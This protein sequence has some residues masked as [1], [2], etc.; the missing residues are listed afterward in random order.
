MGALERLIVIAHGLAV[1][2]GNSCE[3]LIHDVR[4][5]IDKSLVY[6]EN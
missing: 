3:V 6:I 2:F 4:T 1:Q 5:D